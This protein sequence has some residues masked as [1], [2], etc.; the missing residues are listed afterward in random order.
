MAGATASQRK[1]VL[2]VGSDSL[3]GQG[4]R[5]LLEHY[6]CTVTQAGTQR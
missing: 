1:K 2:I 4:L 5:Q 6:D 3:A